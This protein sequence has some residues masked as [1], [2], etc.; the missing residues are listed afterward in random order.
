MKH[1]IVSPLTQSFTT[2]FER[3]G[4]HH[5]NLEYKRGG[6][7]NFLEWEAGLNKSFICHKINFPPPAPPPPPLLYTNN[8]WTFKPK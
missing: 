7:V 5:S 4:V 6:Q 1:V 2:V 8:V 3:M